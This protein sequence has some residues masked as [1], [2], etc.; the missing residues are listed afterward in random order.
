[1]FPR[2]TIV[3]AVF[4]ALNLIPAVQA[5][6]IL[7]YELSDNDGNVTQQT[8][9]ISG[10]W[11]RLDANPKGNSD[12][13]VM[14]LGRMIMFEVDDKGKNYQLTRMGRL[15]WPSTALTSPRFKPIPKKSVVSGVQCQLVSEI[16]VDNEIT[17]KHCMSTGGSLGLNAREMITLSRLFM[18]A[19]RLGLGWPAVATQDERQVSIVSQGAKGAI[20]GFKSVTHG[21][22]PKT[23]FKI[24]VDY[25]RLKPDLPLE[26]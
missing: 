26:Q 19:R 6:S 25:T 14:D 4:V 3:A 8:I 1:M 20:Q 22:I 15:Y 13:L 21:W 23:Q 7:Q 10:R 18:S 2:N 17:A 12:Y 9:S 24:P 5:D 11:L 16:G